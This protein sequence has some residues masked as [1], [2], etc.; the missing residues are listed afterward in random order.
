MK[1]NNWDLAFER[2][3]ATQQKFILAMWPEI[4][5]TRNELTCSPNEL[6]RRFYKFAIKRKNLTKTCSRCGGTGEYS[7]NMRD[8][9]RCFKC[10]GSGVELRRYSKA[11]VSDLQAEVSRIKEAR[12]AKGLS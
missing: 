9:K 2:L 10:N 7:F 6:Y 11:F 12:K 1:A 8:G 3:T 5:H 4:K